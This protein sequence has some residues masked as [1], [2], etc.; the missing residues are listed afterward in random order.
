[1]SELSLGGNMA[2]GD[3]LNRKWNWNGVI[4]LSAENDIFNK[5]FKENITLRPL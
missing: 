2:Y 5:A 1:V 4:D 3:F